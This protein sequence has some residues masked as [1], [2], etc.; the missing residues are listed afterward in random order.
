MPR[1]YYSNTAAPTTLTA[2]VDTVATTITVAALTG[3]PTQFPYTIT[4][5][6]TNNALAE[7]ATV[8]A[9]TGTT[10]TIIRGVD[11]TTAKGHNPGAVVSH[12]HSARDYDEPNAFLNAGGTITGSV[13]VTGLV[14]ASG[15]LAVRPGAATATLTLG[16]ATLT[17][18]SGGALQVN[19]SITAA[20]GLAVTTG[21]AAIGGNLSSTGSILS[22]L[23]GTSGG[24][25]NF[26]NGSHG[27]QRGQAG[28]SGTNHVE[29][30]TAGGVESGFSFR[31]ATTGILF[32]VNGSTK[33][34]TLA[35]LLTANGGITAT[36]S[37]GVRLDSVSSG[38]FS[39]ATSAAGDKISMYADSLGNRHGFGIQNARM[40]AYIPNGQ[41]FAVRDSPATGQASGGSDRHIF[42]A[43]GTA[44][45][46]STLTAGALS[47][48]GAA[49]FNGNVVSQQAITSG[50]MLIADKG[51]EALQIRAAAGDHTYIGFYARTAAQGS[52]SGYMGYGGIGTTTFTFN[53]SLGVF[54]FD[55]A[56]TVSGTL[57]SAGTLSENGSR[58]YSAANP[59]L[60]TT[61]TGATAFGAAAAV[62]TGA[63]FARNDHTHGTPAAPTAASVGALAVT[64]G[65]VTG[66]FTVNK[67]AASVYVQHDATHIGRFVT[68]ALY[69][70]V[71]V[72]NE[73]HVTAPNDSVT[74]A[75]RQLRVSGAIYSSAGGVY[76][77]ASSRV[78]SS[79][80]AN[81]ASTAPGAVVATGVVGSGTAFARND[82]S[83]S[84]VT[85]VAT[86]SG[87]V[88]L[89]AADIAAGSFPAGAFTFNGT[90]N[91]SSGSLQEGGNPV[92]HAG[93]A[94]L[95][96]AAP[97]AVVATGVV[98]TGTS[99]ARNDH[100][101]SGVTSVSAG[102][103]VSVN[104]T[105]GALTV[106]NA[107]V[108]SVNG[109]TGAITNVER[110]DN[111][112]TITATKVHTGQLVV[113]NTSISAFQV[114]SNGANGANIELKNTA[115]TSPIS[116]YFR[117][118]SD[119]RLEIVN[120][121]YSAAVLTLTD[122]G[123]LSSA[124]GF[125]TGG[126]INTTGSY[127]RAHNGLANEI[128]IGEIVGH[129][130]IYAPRNTMCF[131]V[132]NT[133]NW[134]WKRANVERM[135]LN[136]T[137]GEL[138][139]YGG[140]KLLHDTAQQA[141]QTIGLRIG[142]DTVFY[143]VNK[144]NTVG[145]AGGGD[146]ATLQFGRQNSTTG[147]TAT[148]TGD[149]F[150]SS[151]SIDAGRGLELV[152][153]QTGFPAI[154]TTNFAELLT[155]TGDR[156]ELAEF[157]GA[158]NNLVKLNTYLQRASGGNT[159]TTADLWLRRRT[160]GTDQQGINLEAV[161]NTSYWA[162]GHFF[163]NNSGAYTNVNAAAFVVNSA[164]ES[165]RDVVTLSAVEPAHA[166]AREMKGT[167]KTINKALDSSLLDRFRKLR[168][169]S[170]FSVQDAPD[171]TDLEG[172]K[173]LKPKRLHSFV[174][175]EA[176]LVMPEMAA[177][178]LAGV[179]VGIDLS[180]ANAV[181]TAVVQGLIDKV[182]AL[183]TKLASVA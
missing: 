10:L 95:A 91:A 165:K 44:T 166:D 129:A 153:R 87:A 19:T 171:P 31:H 64:G 39:A 28:A 22:T 24:A 100:S 113:N 174:A 128:R 148:G 139:V 154:R 147:I 122:A 103:G 40:V 33:V 59:N 46:T 29:L 76:D 155:S 16:D 79:L 131:Y 182:E 97:G 54:A 65:T 72:T 183:E 180:A 75:Q 157:W 15:D 81:L 83:H 120:N 152:G 134:T 61:V 52:R 70:Y 43:D 175:E 13:T 88:T 26:G 121:A 63:L 178:D 42:N 20:S 30:V 167:T 49:T 3:Y 27:V 164:G 36:G 181:L 170:Y 2:A 93:R 18:T 47:V 146:T 14:T 71:Q 35:G 98:G 123:V 25:L 114:A 105:S 66:D 119:G 145:L 149:G 144:T 161:G 80:N 85:S 55:Q 74:G 99:Y 132:E 117:V 17:K 23:N 151:M 58:V 90:V 9:A 126:D 104:A 94:N 107:G 96:T 115:P 140:L 1:R 82:H 60:A 53:N 111:A 57:N 110:A 69:Q 34:A 142:D 8:T 163:L 89:S 116:K 102:T 11:G 158:T 125:A 32:D 109:A 106:T 12:D 48:T 136:G 133:H 176:A 84:G 45:I 112:T 177:F 135:F 108:T 127:V 68:D 159:W 160:D 38:G 156:S 37:A 6:K 56:V 86:R 7:A 92:Y 62:G 138:T 5:D 162:S 124:A 41:A 141:N 150:T 21:G 51:T 50:G 4:L 78:Y 143:D 173:T 168:P 67:S 130:G 101:H 169:V 137:S 118:L 77:S 172:K 179:P 73:L